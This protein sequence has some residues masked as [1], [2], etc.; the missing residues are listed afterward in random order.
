MESILLKTARLIKLE[1]IGVFVLRACNN[2]KSLVSDKN[3]FK[4]GFPY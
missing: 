3:N 4:V 1:C 2:F